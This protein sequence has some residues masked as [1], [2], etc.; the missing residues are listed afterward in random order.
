VVR[1]AVRR[2]LS[3]IA[4]RHWIIALA[5]V[6]SVKGGLMMVGLPVKLDALGW[7]DA[8]L[9]FLAGL[10]SV[11]YAASCAVYGLVVQRAPLRLLMGLSAALCTGLA[12]G[13]AAV[14]TKPALFV[15][16][17]AYSLGVSLFWPSLMAW[18][19]ES[20]DEHLVGDMAAFNGAWTVAVTVGVLLAGAVEH[21]RSGASLYLVA[22]VSLGLAL[23]I[24]SAHIRGRLASADASLPPEAVILPRRFLAAGWVAAFLV[25]LSM[26]VPDAIFVKLNSELGYSPR[27][28]GFF[29][30]VRGAAQA[31]AVLALGAFQGWRYRR[32]PLVACLLISAGGSSL[33]AVAPGRAVLMLG[34]VLLGAGMGM[35]Y[36]LGFYY[37]IHG[38]RNRKRN[39]GL[40]EALIS[41][42]AILGG[43]LGGLLAMALDRRAPYAGLAAAAGLAALAQVLLLRRAPA[44]MREMSAQRAAGAE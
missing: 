44:R 28:Y 22:A 9:G 11:V 10:S 20:Q 43:P 12:V 16:G 15:L 1:E 7:T 40:F 8:E 5:W 3:S 2:A 19:G 38:R 30:G 29:F 13:L 25:T 21:A 41:S 31:V 17:A 4:G 14:E 24:P 37:S 6:E 42:Q 35:G 27:D 18:I 26:A 39:A 36:S 23:L 34:F 32:W 33:L